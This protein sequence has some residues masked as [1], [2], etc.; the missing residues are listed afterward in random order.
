MERLRGRE[1]ESRRDGETKSWRKGEMV[2]QLEKG[3]M[4]IQRYGERERVRERANYYP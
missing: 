1:I 3:S 4:D 2:R